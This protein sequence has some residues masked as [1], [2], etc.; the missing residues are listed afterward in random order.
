M[1]FTTSMQRQQQARSGASLGGIGS[2]GIELRHDGVFHTWSIFN[3]QP[4]AMGTRL[5]RKFYP[6]S[7]LFFLVR[8]QEEGSEPM[9]R[10]L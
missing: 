6:N 2:G 3:N 4:L 5:P 7:M 9:I 10:L 1:A 8:F